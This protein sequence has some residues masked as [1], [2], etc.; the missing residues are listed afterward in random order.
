MLRLY[1][2]NKKEKTMTKR[3][4]GFVIPLLTCATLFAQDYIMF[5]TVVL[6]LRNGE[7]SALQAGVKKHNAKYHDGTNGP[8]A[9]LWYTHTGPN[10]GT[11]GWGVGPMKF[12]HMDSDLSEDHIRDWEKNVEK[13]AFQRDHV[14]MVR[15][16][17][18]TYNPENEVVGDNILV[19]RI[20]VK[21]GGLEHLQKVE[22]AVTSI[23]DVLRKTNAKIARRVYKSAFRTDKG[24]IMLVYPFSSWTEFE[25]D[26]QG[27]PAGFAD[28]YERINGKGSFKKNVGDILAKHSNGITNEV[29]TMVK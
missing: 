7:H 17:D 14:F 26:R 18:M 4:L 3:I 11:Y 13:Y 12:S 1:D 6:E 25:G 27:L 19:K 15:D 21:Q 8:K 24:D 28:D 16:E 29:Q 20:L 10:S 23:A 9:Y 2:H 22:E 5:N